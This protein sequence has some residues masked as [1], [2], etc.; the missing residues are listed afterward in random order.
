MLAPMV[1][2]GGRLRREPP[3]IGNSH[4]LLHAT[5]AARQWNPKRDSKK[6][7]GGEQ[8]KVG[9]IFIGEWRAGDGSGVECQVEKR[10]AYMLELPTAGAAC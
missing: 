7:G 10:A 1:R 6:V 4:Y 5:I 8:G 2:T 3:A 9:E